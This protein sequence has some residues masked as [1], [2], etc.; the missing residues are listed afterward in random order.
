[1]RLSMNNANDESATISISMGMEMNKYYKCI[2]DRDGS[3]L[4]QV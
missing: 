1:M 4:N 3:R 2:P